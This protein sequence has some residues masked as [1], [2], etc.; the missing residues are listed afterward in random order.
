MYIYGEE[1]T[2]SLRTAINSPTTNVMS[3]DETPYCQGGL[4]LTVLR[5]TCSMCDDQG[6][7]A[8][9]L[10]AQGTHMYREIAPRHTT[11]V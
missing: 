7:Y 6:L 9:M 3:L 11:R 5:T 2:T 10:N 4:L 1:V 8:Q